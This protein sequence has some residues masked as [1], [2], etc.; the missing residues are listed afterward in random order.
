MKETY[1]KGLTTHTGPESC[2]RVSN[3][4]CEALIRVHVGWVLSRV[5]PVRGA[6]TVG[7]G[8]RQHRTNRFGKICL[9]PARSETPCMHGTNLCENREIL[10]LSLQRVNKDR[11]KN[12]K[13]VRTQ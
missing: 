10:C 13:E 3:N 2:A 4:S 1:S 9:N 6:D 11:V 7:G 12:S 8:G 5:I